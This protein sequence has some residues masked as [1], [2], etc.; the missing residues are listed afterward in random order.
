VER[1]NGAGV[2]S[3]IGRVPAKAQANVNRYN[4][5]DKSPFMGVNFYRVKAVDRDNKFAY[6][7]TVNL[8]WSMT[9]VVIYPVPARDVVNLV[10]SNTQ[11]RDMKVQLFNI[12]G[13]VLQEKIYQRVQQATI[14]IYRN[15]M[16]AGV[17]LIRLTDMVSGEAQTEKV[18]FE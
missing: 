4:Y 15:S 13:Q 16:A 3:E 1:S 17:Y 18:I 7:N 5:T 2:F 12:S 8:R 10:I 14:P 9:N 6:T 11:A